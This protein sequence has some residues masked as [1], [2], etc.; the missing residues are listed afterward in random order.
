MK[1][2][3]LD[4]DAV[5]VE[6]FTTAGD[7][8]MQGSVDAHMVSRPGDTFCMTGDEETCWDCSIPRYVC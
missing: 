6:S 8:K 4:V 5:K 3:R 1:K 2:I 7:A